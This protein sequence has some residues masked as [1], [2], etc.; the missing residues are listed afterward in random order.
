MDMNLRA[1]QCFVI[2]AEELNFSRPPSVCI[3]R[4]PR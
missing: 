1:L 4:S 2:L 3:S